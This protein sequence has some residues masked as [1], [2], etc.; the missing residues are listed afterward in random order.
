MTFPDF[1]S[2][3]P[4]RGPV[5]ASISVPG[6]KSL[7]NRSLV[8]AALAQGRTTLLG[9][10][11]SEDTQVMVEALQKLGIEVILSADASNPCN[12][13]ISVRGCGGIIP[14]ESADLFVGTAGT[15]A[16]FLAAFCALGKGSYR[17]HGTPRMHERPM[18]ELFDALR[19]LGARVEAT[20]GRLPVVIGGPLRPGKV[21][22]AGEESSQFA[23]AL[24]LISKI[25][26]LE[27]A[28]P[29][30]SYVTMTRRLLADWEKADEIRDI[31]PDASS[32]SYFL[33]LRHLHGGTLKIARWPK[34]STQIDH[35]LEKFLPPPVRV[36]R[37]KDLGDAVLTLAVT[38]AA[39]RRPFHLVE[40]GNLRK[41]E[42]DRIAA[43][44]TELTRCGVPA[45]GTAEELVLAPARAFQKATIETYHDHR[46]AM[47]FAL[48]GT[49]DG[50]GDGQPWITIQDPGCVAKT[51]PNFF[52]TLEEVR[53]QSAKQG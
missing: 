49:M 37:K 48:L 21:M 52:E 33:A 46:I 38:A 9:A 53:R 28:S 31:E 35:R 42:C 5:C 17:L 47:S 11:W 32:A 18:R 7:T 15:A 8:L 26:R 29:E 40:A 19:Q 10:L 36:S 45:T 25:A 14:V 6:S 13:T 27:V 2:I 51:F 41:Q 43:L 12:R 3:Q 44:A 16:R 39:L 4:L 1:L 22:V 24:L 30:S 20:E 50:M 23:S 34:N